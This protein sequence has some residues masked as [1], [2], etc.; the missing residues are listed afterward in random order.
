LQGK[1]PKDIHAILT[2]TLEE[3]APSYSTLK[4]LLAQFRRGSFSTCYAPRPERQK[5]MTTLDINDQ[6]HELIL[7]DSRP[8]FG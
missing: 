5:P 1:T 3:H 8:D 7:E 4:N 2:E 6:I